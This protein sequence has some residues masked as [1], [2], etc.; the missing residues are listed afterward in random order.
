MFKFGICA[1]LAPQTIEQLERDSALALRTGADFIEIRFDY[2]DRAEF[3]ASLKLTESFKSRSV[4]TLR[5]KAQGGRFEGDE[6]ERISMLQAMAGVKPM[7]LDIE[8][9]ALE[10]S[11]ILADL[12]EKSNTRILVS[13]HDFEKTP[14]AESLSNVLTRMRVFGNH[15]KIV[16]MAQSTEDS[17]SLLRLYDVASGLYPIFFAMGVHGVLS[18]VLCTIIGNAPFTYASLGDA[19]APG[20]LTVKQMR[21][22]YLKIENGMARLT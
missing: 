21:E 12:A 13:W 20:Q 10:S 1:S 2:L 15:V 14:A 17:L 19:V 22:I 11:D 3:E 7:L 6:E 5:S 8:L 4:F 18:R 9:D 16:T